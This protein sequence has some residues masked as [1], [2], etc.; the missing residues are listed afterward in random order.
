MSPAISMHCAALYKGIGRFR[1][2]F[3]QSASSQ[4]KLRLSPESRQQHPVN[5]I[6]D[7]SEIVR[8]PLDTPQPAL[9]PSVPRGS[10]KAKCAK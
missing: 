5:G 7:S 3:A 9:R 4:A 8:F 2:Y 6:Y 10:K 1:L